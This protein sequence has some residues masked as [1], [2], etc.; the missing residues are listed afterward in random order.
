MLLIIGVAL[1]LVNLALLCGGAY[2]VI[3]SRGIIKSNIDAFEDFFTVESEGQVSQFDKVIHSVAK[4]IGGEVAGGVQ[5]SLRNSL[6]GSIKAA[7]AELE[8]EAIAENPGL[9]VM[10]YMPKSMKK[11]PLAFLMF[12]GIINKVLAGKGAGLSG[13]GDGSKSSSA[14]FNL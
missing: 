9:A 12:Q 8:E 6:G 3:K 2:V 10:E 11:N 7:N 4:V 1:I 14:K 5:L 13:G